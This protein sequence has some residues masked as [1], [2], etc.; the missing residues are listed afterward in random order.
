MKTISLHEF[1]NSDATVKFINGLQQ[2]RGRFKRFSCIGE[3]KRQNI[4]VYLSGCSVQIRTKNGQA[5]KIQENGIYYAPYG[6]EYIMDVQHQEHG[7]TIGVNFHL[8]DEQGEP[9]VFSEDILCF[10]ATATAQR[11]FEQM[12]HTESLSSLQCRILLETVIS[13]IAQE[14]STPTV[15]PVIQPSVT[16]LLEH[17]AESP[18]MAQLAAL[19]HISEVYFRRVFKQSFQM[20]PA[21]Y[22]TSLKLKKAA[23]HLEYGDMSVQEIADTVGYGGAAYFS[24]EFKAAYGATPLQYR[25]DKRS[26]T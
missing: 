14:Q 23:E 24:K 5:L 4:L 16:Y 13:E 22:M 15:P 8:T 2:Y 3:P 17:Y 9:F 19:S 10:R 21:A 20:T 1:C 7:S 11:A 12:A 6:S 25:K 18:S 26:G